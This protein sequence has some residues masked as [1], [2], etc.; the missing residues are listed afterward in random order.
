M[1]D[2]ESRKASLREYR[3]FA[4]RAA[5]ELKYPK[6]VIEKIRK[7]KTENEITCIMERQRY[8]LS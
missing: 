2:I 6:E 4:S 5:C 3:R 8:S 1:T 7:A